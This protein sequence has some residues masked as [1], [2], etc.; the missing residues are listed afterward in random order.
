VLSDFA[1]AGGR[2]SRLRNFLDDLVQPGG[3][4]V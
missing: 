2:A 1:G 4:V 3:S